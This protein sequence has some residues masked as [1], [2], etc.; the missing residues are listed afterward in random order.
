MPG[1]SPTAT[2]QS[3]NRAGIR[4]RGRPDASRERRY[5]AGV[6]RFALGLTA[7]NA[8][9]SPLRVGR[10]TG[11]A[12]VSY[13]RSRPWHELVQLRVEAVQPL[14]AI[15]SRTPLLCVAAATVVVE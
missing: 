6:T 15:T 1:A 5:G 2:D 11:I 4:P 9:I 14:A 10:G 3:R 7:S 13:Q 12:E 8:G